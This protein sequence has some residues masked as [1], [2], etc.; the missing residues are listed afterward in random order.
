MPGRLRVVTVGRAWYYR[1][2]FLRS[3]VGVES[4]VSFAAI[5]GIPATHGGS[6]RR[7][8]LMALLWFGR[9]GVGFLVGFGGA[10]EAGQ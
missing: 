5:D 9:S 2:R 10:G 4:T 6:C 7:G 8:C 1:G 3:F